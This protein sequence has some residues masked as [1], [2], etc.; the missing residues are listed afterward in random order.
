MG[1]ALDANATVPKAVG[2]IQVKEQ[3]G[4]LSLLDQKVINALLYYSHDSMVDQEAV[5]EVPMQ[6]LRDY[7]GR[8]ESNDQVRTCLTNLSEVILKFDYID[9]DGDRKWGSGSLITVSGHETGG[10]GV[11]RFTW[12]HWLRPLLA[13]PAKWAR[14]SMPVV[15][16][17]Q[18]KYGI[19]LYE[20]LETVANRQVKE[21]VVDIEDLRVLLGVGDKLKEWRDFCRRA[22]AP[23]LA[24]VNTLA[25]FEATWTVYRQRGRKVLS[26]RFTVR[27]KDERALRE[28]QGRAAKGGEAGEM[29][30]RPETY[31]LARR[32]APGADIYRIEVEFKAWCAG[33]PRPR[34]VDGA[35]IGFVKRWAR[36]RQ[37]EL[38]F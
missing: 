2:L 32:S 13:E 5:H 29:R 18:S 31:E 3:A 36:N 16:A 20:N 14:V 24:E 23:A 35:F 21:W 7:L 28:A 15:R 30:L 12:P 10:E 25:D 37:G 9:T 1:S 27:K 19:R 17:F 6:D 34:N 11:V 33:K 22:V 38:L 4:S 26:L 8:H